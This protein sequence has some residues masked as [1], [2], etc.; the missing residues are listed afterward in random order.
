[1]LPRHLHPL[2]DE[3]FYSTLCR[4][5]MLSGNTK[6]SATFRSIFGKSNP[7][8][9]HPLPYDIGKFFKHFN[10]AQQKTRHEFLNATT[11]LP[12]LSVWLTED[13]KKLLYKTMEDSSRRNWKRILSFELPY[14]INQ[15]SIKFCP[16]CIKYDLKVH[17]VAYWHRSHQLPGVICCHKHHKLLQNQIFQKLKTKYVFTLELP[18]QMEH[19]PKNRASIDRNTFYAGQLQARR[20]SNFIYGFLNNSDDIQITALGAALRHSLNTHRFNPKDLESNVFSTVASSYFK[21]LENT[22]YPCEYMRWITSFFG[23]GTLAGTTTAHSYYYALNEIAQI[24]FLFH[25]FLKLRSTVILHVNTNSLDK[26]IEE[27]PTLK[28]NLKLYVQKQKVT[29]NQIS[30]KVNKNPIETWCL[31]RSLRILPVESIHSIDE[32]IRSKVL[33]DLRFGI[34]CNDIAYNYHLHSDWIDHVSMQDTEILNAYQHGKAHG[35]LCNIRS[36]FLS[37]L[38]HAWQKPD[39]EIICK[40]PDTYFTLLDRDRYWLLNVMHAMHKSTPNFPGYSWSYK[41]LY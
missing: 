11:L 33:S 24:S 27:T 35:K 31:L 9:S 23:E 15:S 26:E 7:S 12:L 20:I 32:P 21:G 18:N 29:C 37:C 14:T 39:E 1:M 13:R 17:G 6:P 10:V 28:K 3:S 30:L 2:P 25:S 16:S 36:L 40:C 4:Y 8:V 22:G 38:E 41:Y 5:H 19:S 34:N